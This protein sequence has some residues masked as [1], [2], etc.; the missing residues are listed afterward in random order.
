[1]SCSMCERS[2]EA[3]E[4]RV[5]LSETLKDIYTLQCRADLDTNHF[6]VFQAQPAI[7]AELDKKQN[8]VQCME[9]LTEKYVAP[10][11]RKICRDFY[12][13]S[14]LQE[15]L[16]GKQFLTCVYQDVGEQWLLATAVPE[17]MDPDGTLHSVV[18]LVR[19]ST[20]QVAERITTQDKLKKSNRSLDENQRIL[21]SMQNIYFSGFYVDLETD[22]YRTLFV[23]PWIVDF[24]P[25]V[26]RFSRFIQDY[27]S[28]I[29]LPECHE[30]LQRV[31]SRS[32]IQKALHK[33]TLTVAR[34]CF[35]Q[36]YRSFRLG[37]Y[38]WNRVT[39][40]PVDLDDS[41]APIHVLVML[42][43]ITDAK[44]TEMEYQRQ[45]LESARRAQQ[46]NDA[47]TE[48]LHRISHDI[49][50]PING[51]QGMLRI[52]EYYGDDPVKRKQCRDK[53]WS[54][55]NYL[56]DLVNDVLDMSKLESGN[57]KLEM[58]PFNMNELL[59][60]INPIM[61]AQTVERG[62]QYEV[63]RNPRTHLELV[64]ST[65][66][67]RQIL[68]NIAGNALKYNRPGGF[69][70]VACRELS[71][72]ED[73][74]LYQFVCED[75]GQGMSKEFQKRMF[76][77]FT[78]EN[79]DARTNYQGTGLGLAITKGL[80]DQMGG[81]IEVQ[82]EK[83]VGSTFTV[84]LPLA[85]NKAAVTAVRPSDS[86]AQDI[87]RGTTILL[88]EDNALNAEVAEF[89]LERAGASV[90]KAWNGQEGVEQFLRSSPGEI[91]AILMD[92]MMPVLDGLSAARRLRALDRPD[93][94][95]IPIVAMTANAF[96]DDMEKTRE[97]GMNAH[98]SKPLDSEKLLTVLAKLIQKE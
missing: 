93:A 69:I 13:L 79:S 9:H 26:G 66:Y 78:Q 20:A 46:A 11:Y 53:I 67:I 54:A 30:E 91:D 28:F 40:I 97:A 89:L 48:F 92:V 65:L 50:T 57:L 81:T 16:R 31:L 1:M 44:Q 90:L 41:G 88:V 59:D 21:H 45:I 87:L 8:A 29:V 34:H 18:F 47:K 60:Q 61:E 72:T 98:L 63:V 32:Y 35:T 23:A 76:E 82:S 86:P 49:R 17:R 10:A 19:N 33:E 43:D 62:I 83:D 3:M 12:D 74:A 42:Q 27:L 94:K 95:T 37:E 71:S 68:L 38:K 73:T 22:A 15:R 55:S 6:Y 24:T 51:I 85:I 7:K 5:D 80:I 77:P 58:Q 84:N 70:K 14:T 52:A 36:D 39:I 2:E 4:Q 25:P 64:G 75:S 96:V 56:L